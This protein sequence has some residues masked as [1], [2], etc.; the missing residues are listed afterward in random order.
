MAY[1]S[2]AAAL[3]NRDDYKYFLRTCTPDNQ[4]TQAM[5]DIVL[6]T[7]SNY[8][9][10]VY[11][12]EAYGQGGKAGIEAVAALKRVCVVNTHPVTDGGSYN[13]ILDELRK[14]GHAKFVIVMVRSHMV[15]PVV[16]AIINQMNE[17]EFLLLGSEAWSK[18]GFV[19]ENKPK[20]KG[21][22]S[23]ALE[24]P[25]AGFKDYY[26]EL[27]ITIDSKIN[28]WLQTYI[29]NKFNCH[30]PL[31]FNKTATEK[32]TNI[33]QRLDDQNYQ[34]DPWTPFAIYAAKA[35]LTGVDKA[36]K[37]LCGRNEIKLCDEYR[38]RTQYVYDSV[39]E[40]CMINSLH[41]PK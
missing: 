37:T 5:I 33:P 22:F 2:T 13:L 38:K 16:H 25:M 11:S 29:E 27:D 8:I 24:M 1:A 35:L 17:G 10:I 18:N 6:E 15:V 19:I 39:K 28:P 4:Q 23:L 21:F 41:L 26:R 30:Y 3:S 9:Q 32:C 31:S 36:F 12:D 14:N 20:T 7:G 34:H 40:V